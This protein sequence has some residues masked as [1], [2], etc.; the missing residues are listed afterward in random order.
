MCTKHVLQ[1]VLSTEN[2]FPSCETLLRRHQYKTQLYITP[3]LQYYRSVILIIQ[4]IGQCINSV[5][6]RNSLLTPSLF[7]ILTTDQEI[8]VTFMF[9]FE[10][11]NNLQSITCQTSFP[12][13]IA[14]PS[15]CSVSK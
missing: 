3:F 12:L 10:M 6:S 14:F 5:P 11:N 13:D 1:K 8:K 9:L 15:Q 7:W 4:S 2:I